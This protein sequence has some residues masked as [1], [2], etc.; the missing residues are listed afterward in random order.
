MRKYYKREFIDNEAAD[1]YV[2]FRVDYHAPRV[3]KAWRD[4]AKK[5]V[6][7]PYVYASAKLADCYRSISWDF[8][9]YN[10]L[11]KTMKLMNAFFAKATAAHEQAKKDQALY[12]KL[13]KE[14][15]GRKSKGKSS[16]KG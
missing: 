16:T 10:K 13:K 6:R 7:K 12:K 15:D 1:S 4:A 5:E 2:V 9:D 11:K 8:E 3:E 14:H